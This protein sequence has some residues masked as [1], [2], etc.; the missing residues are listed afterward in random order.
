MF[1]PMMFVRII[2]PAAGRPIARMRLRPSTGYG[3]GE[4]LRTGGSHHV[5]FHTPLLRYRVTTNASL[6]AL[7]D[8]GW[9]VV[10]APLAFVLGPDETLDDAPL[11]VARN[12]LSLTIAYWQDWIRGLAI[13]VE[14]QEAVIRAAITL[15]LCTFEDTGAVRRGT[16]DLDPEARAT[17]AAT[18]TTGICWLRD[19]YFVIQALN[20]LGATRTMEGYLRYIDNV[21]VRTQGGE[22]QAALRHRRRGAAGRAGRAGAAR[23]PR[24][25]TRARRQP[26]VYGRNRT[27]S[28]A[29]SCSRA[30]QSFF[31]KRLI[32]PGNDELFMRLERFGERAARCTTNPMP[33]RGSSAASSRRTRSP[34][35]CAGPAATACSENRRRH[36]ACPSARAPGASARPRSVATI[37]D[38]AWSDSRR[39]HS[40]RAS[41]ARKSTRRRCCSRNSASCRH[42]HALRADARCRD[43]A[44]WRAATDL[45]RYRHRD[46][47]GTPATA[48]TICAFWYVDALAAA[49]RRD[50][51]RDAVPAPAR[52]PH[53]ARPALGG[54]RP[55]KRRT[56]GQF[57]ADLQHGRH[58]QLRRATEPAVGRRAVS[59]VVAV[60]N[61]VSV[62]RRDV[63]AR[64]RSRSA[65]SPPAGRAAVCGSAGAARLPSASPTAP[66]RDPRPTSRTRRST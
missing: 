54:H 46:D 29:P 32:V 44:T 6:S 23:L 59:R 5:C 14:W 2:E 65:C 27:T 1:R 10:D 31:D 50:E 64:R 26:R 15:K 13:P 9:F 51:A 66:P 63:D 21:V 20:R 12:F 58:H 17:A 41:A 28:T 18:G 53:S 62:Q 56:V 47:F 8:A 55:R 3:E 60:S 33:A 38:Q 39:R 42:G 22:L 40:R 30:T 24:H 45:F 49:G 37:L 61:R 11:T 35:R 4:P 48:F 19:S 57:P 16:D 7:A 43:A 52:T 34:P 25:G 36:S